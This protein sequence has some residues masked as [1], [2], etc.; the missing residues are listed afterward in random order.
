MNYK[1]DISFKGEATNLVNLR[2][3][4]EKGLLSSGN[5]RVLYQWA[6]TFVLIV[7]DRQILYNLI[8]LIGAI[9]A[10]YVS[11]WI[12]CLLLLTISFRS[13]TIKNIV[14]AVTLHFKMLIVTAGFGMIISFIYS[15]IAFHQFY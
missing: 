1:N 2:E 9:L 14:R 5:L 13:Q 3:I 11:L 10:E 4:I 8:Y 6:N 15:F 7:T 12:Y